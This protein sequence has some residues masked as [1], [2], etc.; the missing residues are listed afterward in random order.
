[1]TAFEK[2]NESF[3]GG[4]QRVRSASTHR[5]REGVADAC[6]SISGDESI[7]VKL[8]SGQRSAIARA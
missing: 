1:M 6:L 8:R 7:A 5:M 4:V 2:I 3:S